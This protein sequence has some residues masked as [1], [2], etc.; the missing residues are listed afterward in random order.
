M[1]VKAVVTTRRRVTR[2][3]ATGHGSRVRRP[4]STA[5]TAADPASTGAIQMGKTSAGPGGNSQ[6]SRVYTVPRDT[7]HRVWM[8]VPRCYALAAGRA[9]RADSMVEL[10][11]KRVGCTPNS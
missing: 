3:R 11:A 9:A 5:I 7:T 4:T 6:P 1:S 10:R 8:R 2:P